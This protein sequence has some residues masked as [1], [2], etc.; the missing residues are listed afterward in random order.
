LLIIGN[1][2]YSVLGRILQVAVGNGIKNAPVIEFTTR[3]DLLHPF[4][5]LLTGCQGFHFLTTVP[6][7]NTVYILSLAPISWCGRSN[8]RQFE[9]DN[10]FF[11][12]RRYEKWPRKQQAILAGFGGSGVPLSTLFTI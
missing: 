3:A 10:V 6:I 2:L 11:D 1:R 9:Q 8:T 12:Y 4:L 7:C 5:I